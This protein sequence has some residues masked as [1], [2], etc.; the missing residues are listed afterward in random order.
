[1]GKNI[2]DSVLKKIASLIATVF[3]VGY[4]PKMPG[5]WGTIPGLVFYYFSPIPL[6]IPL[7]FFLG[8]GATYFMLKDIEEPDP[9]YVVI[10]EVVGVMLTLSFVP[11]ASIK[12][13]LLGFITFRFFD[14]LKPWPIKSMECFF[15]K[16]GKSSQAFG[17]MIDDVFAGIMAG[18][19]CFVAK[20]LLGNF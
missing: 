12:M 20:L 11:G 18:L 16:K 15:E 6:F 9:S 1:M 13:A 5:T 2:I 17:V 3:Y 19:V 8:W 14:I 7:L 4:L 10:D